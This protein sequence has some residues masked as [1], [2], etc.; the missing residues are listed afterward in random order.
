MHLSGDVCVSV[1][2]MCAEVCGC[3][4]LCVYMHLGLCAHVCVTSVWMC[5][6]VCLYVCPWMGLR[7]WMCI[8]GDGY[9]CLYV[10]C[11]CECGHGVCVEGVRVVVEVTDGLTSPSWGVEDKRQQACGHECKESRVSPCLLQC[12]GQTRGG[13]FGWGFQWCETEGAVHRS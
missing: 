12:G 4:L 2:V 8:C 10:F 11:V 3:V 7:V 9:M 13:W 6:H 5:P 1:S